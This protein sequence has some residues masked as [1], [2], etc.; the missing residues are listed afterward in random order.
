MDKPPVALSGHKRDD[1]L[2]ICTAA[3]RRLGLLDRKTAAVSLRL[4]AVHP[5][6]KAE[7]PT[8]RGI[9]STEDDDNELM[10]CSCVSIS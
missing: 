3:F 2:A 4:L 1:F 7:R 5:I 6:R 10:V 8:C 9:V